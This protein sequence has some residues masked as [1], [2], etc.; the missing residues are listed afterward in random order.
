MFYV[1]QKYFENLIECLVKSI[2]RTKLRSCE[3]IGTDR[4]WLGL[5]W[6]GLDWL[7]LAGTV[8]GTGRNQGWLFLHMRR[9]PSWNSI[10]EIIKTWKVIRNKS[11]P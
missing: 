3:A 8:A 9:Y 6:T 2:S 11:N 5:A 10:R 1:I 4:D 7:G